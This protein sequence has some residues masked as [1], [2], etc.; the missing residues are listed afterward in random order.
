MPERKR[1]SVLT[2][3]EIAR[4][5]REKRILEL[6]NKGKRQNQSNAAHQTVASVRSTVPAS[7][8]D[9]NVDEVN[10]FVVDDDAAAVDAPRHHQSTEERLF[11]RA[12][13]RQQSRRRRALA[14]R[15]AFLCS[16]LHSLPSAPMY[17][18][19]VDPR[20]L[21]DALTL[22]DDGEL[23]TSTNEIRRWDAEVCSL[24]CSPAFVMRISLSQWSCC[25]TRC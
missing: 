19:D 15:S 8:P 25:R 6:A 2:E 20:R 22:I 12:S 11:K 1:T 10:E 14:E 7:L 4:N 24:Q 17:L 23:P 9:A 5:A 3:A 13:S 16:D 18:R 21:V